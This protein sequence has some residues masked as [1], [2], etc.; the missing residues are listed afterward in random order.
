MEQQKKKIIIIQMTNFLLKT[1]IKK[2]QK[3]N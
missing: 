1:C 2:K 3:E